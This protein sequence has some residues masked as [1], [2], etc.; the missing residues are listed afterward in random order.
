MRIPR[1]VLVLVGLAACDHVTLPRVP[2][3][4]QANEAVQDRGDR[5]RAHSTCRK[6]TTSVDGMIGCMQDAGWAFVTRGPGYPAADCWQS[7]DR[8]E[9]D[10]VIALCFT[11]TGG[12]RTGAAP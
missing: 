12:P 5:Y 7:R 10:G 2:Q 1:A 8:G 4:E 3:L 6:A 9:M 11:R